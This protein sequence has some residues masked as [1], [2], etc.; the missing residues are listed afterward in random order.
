MRIPKSPLIAVLVG[1]SVAGIA[2]ASAAS[3]GG[4]TA[5]SLGSDDSVIAS[6]DT[7]GITIG[8]T[9]AYDATNQEYRTSAVNFSGVNAA[10]NGKAASV[11]LRNGTTALS[12]ATSASI[13]VTAG[14]FT[15]TLSSPITSESVDGV[16]LVISG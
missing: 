6:C 11:S 16:S 5:G 2:G 13:T 7:D 10:C 15:L 4:L 9:T 8:Y 1:V 14:A 12:T 3:L